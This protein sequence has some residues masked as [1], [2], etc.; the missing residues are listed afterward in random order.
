MLVFRC[1]LCTQQLALNLTRQPAALLPNPTHPPT[2]RRTHT[3]THKHEHIY[4]H[5]HTHTHTHLPTHRPGAAARHRAA[6]H[7]QPGRRHCGTRP[8]GGGGSGGAE[9]EGGGGGGTRRA[10]RS[11]QDTRCVLWCCCGVC[12]CCEW[13][14]VP[15]VMVLLSPSVLRSRVQHTPSMHSLPTTSPPP[16]THPPALHRH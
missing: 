10:A 9:G 15:S 14:G 16:P 1:K 3:H 6:S 2:P 11:A 13:D 12:G 5:T 8:H 4:T 7:P